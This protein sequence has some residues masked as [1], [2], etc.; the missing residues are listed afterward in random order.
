MKKTFFGAAALALAALTT[1]VMAQNEDYPNVISATAGLNLLQL[2]ATLDDIDENASSNLKIRGTA[3]YGLTYDHAINKWFSI[4]LGGA[5][6]YFS[7]KGEVVTIEKEDGTT[8]SGPVKLALSR[9]NIGVRP[10]F[11]YVNG[12]RLDMYSGLRVGVNVWGVTLD[13]DEG[14]LPEDVSNRARDA[15]VGLGMQFIPLGLRWYATPNL[16][17]GFETGI[18]APHYAALQLNYRMGGDSGSKSKKSGKRK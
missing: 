11:H 4:G 8:Y 1:P 3:S 17:F 2:V 13:A 10:L 16:G 5:Y 12:G 9:T 15:G 6:N 18:G 7:L 14:L